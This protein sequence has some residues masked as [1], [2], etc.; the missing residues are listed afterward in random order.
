MV[1]TPLMEGLMR[2]NFVAPTYLG[3]THSVDVVIDAGRQFAQV[4]Q[5]VSSGL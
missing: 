2:S 3:P 5:R 1:G 4:C